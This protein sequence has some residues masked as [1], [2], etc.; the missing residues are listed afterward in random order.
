MFA[1]SRRRERN[2]GSGRLIG[3]SCTH[4]RTP[5]PDQTPT[6][7]GAGAVGGASRSPGHGGASE[8]NHPRPDRKDSA[9]EQGQ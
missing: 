7:S 1:A 4:T 5:P 3:P 8:A 6:P 2:Y 9:R